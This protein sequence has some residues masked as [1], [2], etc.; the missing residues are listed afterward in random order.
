MILGYFIFDL[1]VFAQYSIAAQEIPVNL[2]QGLVCG[3]LG[4]VLI[5]YLPQQI[6]RARGEE[7]RRVH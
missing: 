6:K 7:K 4:A 5:R 2:A 3:A 1:V